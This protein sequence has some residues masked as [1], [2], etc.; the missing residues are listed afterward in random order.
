M[1]TSSDSC[2]MIN[3]LDLEVAVTSFRACTAPR[4][5]ESPHLVVVGSSHSL[6]IM[7]CSDLLLRIA[8][9]HQS[10]SLKLRRLYDSKRDFND[11]TRALDK[12]LSCKGALKRILKTCANDPV[13]A[14]QLYSSVRSL[15]ASESNN[16]PAK[17]LYQFAFEEVGHYWK[18]LGA[19]LGFR[20]A[21]LT[22]I[23]ERHLNRRLGA[24]FM[25]WAML[26][27]Y[28]AANGQELS[29]IERLHTKLHEVKRLRKA[30]I[31]REDKTISDLLP[32]CI[33]DDRRFYG[34]DDE[35]KEI[36]RYLWNGKAKTS[37]TEPIDSQK[38]QIVSGVGGVGK[39]TL[40]FKYVFQYA[41]SYSDGVFYF[42]AESY[43]SVHWCLKEN[44]ERAA[45]LDS[46]RDVC[47]AVNS[48]S[49]ACR[50]FLS[51]VRAHPRS[52]LLFDN[53]DDFDLVKEFLPGS[54]AACHIIITT[55]KAQTHNIVY[56]RNVNSLSLTVLEKEKAVVALL[57]WSGKSKESLQVLEYN[58]K[59]YAKK[60]ATEPPVEGLPLALCHAG[61]F[62]EQHQVTFLMYWRKIEA[63]AKRLEA[64]ALNLDSFLRYFHLSHLKE[65]LRQH[66]VSS[67]NQFVRLDPRNI[68][69]YYDQKSVLVAQS[70]YKE[71]ERH[72][73]FLTWELDI[74]DVRDDESQ[75]GYLFLKC[76]SIMSSRDIPLDVVADAA[77]LYERNSLDKQFKVA[78]AIKILNERSLIQ[79]V[80]DPDNDMN[81]T[82]SVH[83]LIQASVL[84]R[85]GENATDFHSIL[86]LVAKALL[87][88]LPPLEDLNEQTTSPTLL[89][90]IPHIY[91]TVEKMLRV[92]MLDEARPGLIDYGCFLALRYSHHEDGKRLCSLRVEV[93]EA[94]LATFS[95]EEIRLRRRDYYCGL[96]LSQFLGL[97]NLEE[98]DGIIRRALGGTCLEDLSS[99]DVVFYAE[100]LYLLAESQKLQNLPDCAERTLQRILSAFSSEDQLNTREMCHVLLQL[101]SVYNMS[102]R[103]E[104]ELRSVKRALYL[105][106]D[107]PGYM[108]ADC[109]SHLGCCQIA[110]GLCDEASANYAEALKIYQEILPD[111]HPFLGVFRLVISVSVLQ[112]GQHSQ[113]C[114]LSRESL[115]VIRSVCPPENFFVSFALFAH[116]RNL[117]ASGRHGESIAFLKES[118]TG[119]EEGPQE[120]LHLLTKATC[121]ALLGAALRG[122][123]SVVN[124]EGVIRCLKE[125]VSILTKLNA[126]G[127][128]ELSLA[129]HYFYLCEAYI[130]TGKLDEAL[131]TAKMLWDS[132]KNLP[133]GNYKKLII[134]SLYTQCLNFNGKF[135]ESQEFLTRVFEES[136]HLPPDHPAIKQLR[137]AKFSLHCLKTGS[138]FWKMGSQFFLEIENEISGIVDEDVD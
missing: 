46:S 87:K 38:I 82:F 54:R 51:Y 128:R 14:R 125:S 17:S 131:V 52:L 86:K 109:H 40:A 102:G 11:S 120:F 30:D 15:N 114:E 72:R 35:M 75:E 57:C 107:G 36:A 132:A 6:E 79:Q 13:V 43:P 62:V 116:G 103:L 42:N 28:R 9:E 10:S 105:A 95:E 64:A 5:L 32:R 1:G 124:R 83:H 80:T 118:L 18:E 110:R 45:D 96:A 73:V 7:Q 48:I 93:F 50:Y 33:V 65:N 70:A 37:Q 68:G 121:L 8:D 2:A 3:G 34:R 130:K 112:T 4:T 74:N 111:T 24:K 29:S 77:F 117:H 99:R 123:N 63:E 23:E 22:D 88:R 115:S 122:E 81:V 66:R 90:L 129:S 119:L 127:K 135:S 20:M 113:A 16:D 26:E 19:S 138:A 98:I 39:T 126:A 100:V 21:E 84:Q 134:A 104:D 27:K 94:N 69:N 136:K 58:E 59:K 49:N 71:R 89:S 31:P 137:N 55:R 53:A 25:A 61:T 108:L 133:A 97:Q 47:R 91:S 44:I 106:K 41:E 76:C 56:Q 67:V 12:R 60:V 78:K 101:S 85:M 92:G